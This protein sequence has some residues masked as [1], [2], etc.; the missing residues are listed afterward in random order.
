MIFSSRTLY[1]GIPFHKLDI[2]PTHG[3]Y[4]LHTAEGASV[5]IR[6]ECTHINYRFTTLPWFFFVLSLCPFDIYVGIEAFTICT[7]DECHALFHLYLIICE[8]TLVCW[9]ILNR[10]SLLL[11]HSCID[12]H[13]VQHIGGHPFGQ[14]CEE[15]L[16]L[17]VLQGF[18]HELLHTLCVLL[19]RYEASFRFQLSNV[20]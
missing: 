18:C 9:C 3:S 6:L 19:L 5:T 11:L 20:P 16:P 1:S 2:L 12:V 10:P 8:R 14:K 13:V 15:Y 7:S 17:N 4:Q